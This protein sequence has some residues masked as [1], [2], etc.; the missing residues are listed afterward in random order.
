MMFSRLSSKRNITKK[1]FL[2]SFMG[3]MRYAQ[4]AGV[5][6]G[7]L[8]RCTTVFLFFCI[9]F[10]QDILMA[11]TPAES[12]RSIRPERANCAELAETANALIALGETQAIAKLRG[13]VKE[14]AGP[15]FPNYDINQFGWLCRMLFLPQEGKTLRSIKVEPTYAGLS[16]EEWPFYP[17]IE[18]SGV[19]FVSYIPTKG[20]HRRGGSET[21]EEYLNYCLK[22]GRLRTEP[23]KVPTEAEALAA[24]D[25]FLESPAWRSLQKLKEFDPRFLPEIIAYLKRQT[26]PD[27][28]MTPGSLSYRLGLGML[29][30][31]QIRENPPYFK[32]F[33][34]NQTAKTLKVRVDPQMFQGAIVVCLDGKSETETEVYFDKNYLNM[35]ETKP[36]EPP[37]V[38]LAAYEQISWT[39]PLTELRRRRDAT[40]EKGSD[41]TITEQKLQGARV[42]VRWDDLAIVPNEKDYVKSNAMQVSKPFIIG[43]R[44]KKK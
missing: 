33:L 16:Q 22:N 3:N 43:V 2:H 23:L 30:Q 25:K 11:E 32:V 19:F 34:G 10:Q 42:Y 37:I 20:R 29:F 21:P 17:L 15:G 24:L 9:F 8:R 38:K 7:V 26:K 18:N 12:W 40:E 31:L 5:V 1:S 39:I 13:S 44:K 27:D 36:Q 14:G 41:T 6:A 28:P 35:L 4:I